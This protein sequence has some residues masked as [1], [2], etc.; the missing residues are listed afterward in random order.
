L[1]VYLAASSGGSSALPLLFVIL[2]IGAMYFLMIRPQQ[3]R[4]REMQSMQASLGPGAEVMTGSGI[5]GEVVEIDESEGTVL[6]E[7][8][9]D[10]VVKFARGAIARTI[11]SAPQDAAEA[12]DEADGD[13]VG[14][15]SPDT[16]PP[17]AMDD[18]PTGAES[19][20][21]RRKD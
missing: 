5:Y 2:I 18:R 8:A 21:E 4:N 11:S 12:D 17:S 7:I 9:P 6:L 16:H 20:I 10:I 13:E 14:S 19:V 15:V 1:K 3:R